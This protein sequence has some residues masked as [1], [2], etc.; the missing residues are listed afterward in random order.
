MNYKIRC[1]L[2]MAYRIGRIITG[3]VACFNILI[4]SMLLAENFTTI[5]L[6]FLFLSFI[7]LVALWKTSHFEK[8]FT[9]D[10]IEIK[11]ITD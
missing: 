6:F 9:K 8:T 3:I 11:R 4:Q 5:P 7:V 1:I 10:G 2:F